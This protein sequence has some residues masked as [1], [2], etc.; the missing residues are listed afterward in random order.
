M[1]HVFTLLVILCSFYYT[2]AQTTNYSDRMSHIFGAIDKTKVTSGYLKEFGIRFNS[3]ES[4]N[5]ILYDSNFVDNSQWE[6]LYNSLYSMRVGN[7][8]SGMTS[9]S[10][11]FQHLKTQQTSNPDVVLL[12]ALHYT[13][14]QYKTTAY[15]NG[16]VTIVNDRIYDVS[17]RNPYENKTA[18]AVNPMKHYL[19]GN[20]FS[21]KLPS[22]MLYSN[23]QYALNW[24]QVDFDNGQGYQT[25]TLDNAINITYSSGGEKEIKIKFVHSNDVPE[26]SHA[27]LYIDYVPSQAQ[28]RF[29]G[30]GAYSVSPAIVGAAYLSFGIRVVKCGECGTL[31]NTV[32]K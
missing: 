7:V 14:Q 15:T 27:K 21:F 24:V 8:A 17:G 11:V 23:N 5:G 12:A 30:S 9:P 28:A 16:D 4:Y 3:V 25:I 1:K 13:Y 18:F 22:N 10:I 2:Q 29:S 26:Y 31:H 32:F 6:S 20:T 19:T